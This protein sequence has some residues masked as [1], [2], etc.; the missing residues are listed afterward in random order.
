MHFIMYNFKFLNSLS[1]TCSHTHKQ[2]HSFYSCGKIAL[3]KLCSIC[4][5][6]SSSVAGFLSLDLYICIIGYIMSFNYCFFPFYFASLFNKYI[7]R[8]LFSFSYTLWSLFFNLLS[9]FF[10]HSLFVS[11]VLDANNSL[12]AFLWTSSSFFWL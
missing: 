9:E 11:F 1:H 10:S 3:N 5:L 2:N 6:I 7:F 8:F 4:L 12:W